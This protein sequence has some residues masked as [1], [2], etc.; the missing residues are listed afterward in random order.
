MF[1]YMMSE[2]IP[3]RFIKSMI[4]SCEIFKMMVAISIVPIMN[5]G[6]GTKP[7]AKKSSIVFKLSMLTNINYYKWSLSRHIFLK[8]TS[9]QCNFFNN[10]KPSIIKTVVINPKL[11]M[12]A[13]QKHILRNLSLVI[14]SVILLV[15]FFENQAFQSWTKL[16]IIIFKAVYWILNIAIRALAL[17]IRTF[18]LPPEGHFQNVFLNWHFKK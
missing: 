17:S 2:T 18:L 8:I 1:K 4:I 10:H 14:F 9:V 5:N 13:T 15:L 11:K 16:F 12:F 7:N 6:M 3:V